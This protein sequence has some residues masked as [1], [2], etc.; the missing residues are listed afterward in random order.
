MYFNKSDEL[1][2]LDVGL[3]IFHKQTTCDGLTACKINYY[4]Y[5]IRIFCVHFL[6]IYIFLKIILQG[7]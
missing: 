5:Y 1:A 3:L 7:F 2:T 4:Y 6:S